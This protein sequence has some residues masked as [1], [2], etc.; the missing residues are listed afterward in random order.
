MNKCI[1]CGKEFYDQI[2]EICLECEESLY[3]TPNQ[4]VIDDE[5]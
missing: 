2:Y 1:M 3:W 5:K 4:E